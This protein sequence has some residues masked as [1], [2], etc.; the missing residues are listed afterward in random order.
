MGFRSRRRSFARRR[1]HA[2]HRGVAAVVGTLLAL[3]VFLAIFGIFLSDYLPLWMQDNE[4]S[5]A[6]QVESQFGGIQNTMGSEYLSSD[7]GYQA[8]NPVTMQSG[9]VPVFAQP[10]QG[11]L[12]FTGN[13]QLFTNVSFRLDSSTGQAY[14]QN[15]TTVGDLTMSLP[16]RYYV[17]MTFDLQ[18]GGVIEAQSGASQQNMIFAPSVVA[19]S[20]GGVSTLYMTL[21]A[22]Y[23]NNSVLNLPTAVVYTTFL[24]SQQYPGYA[25]TYVDVNFTTQYPCAWATYWNNTFGYLNSTQY[26]STLN[27]HPNPTQACVPGGTGGVTL[28]HVSFSAVSHFILSVADFTVSVGQST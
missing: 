10:T 16:N 14:Y 3:L 4:Q 8:A 1:L 9:G 2:S 28:M 18:N 23:G 20:S 19:N 7:A 27:V 21:F 15:I 6:A 24:A 13:H 17:P 26:P 22:L 25:G 12:S 11:I 5:L